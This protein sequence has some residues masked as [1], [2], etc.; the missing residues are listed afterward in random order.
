MGYDH[1]EQKELEP[2]K[3]AS[4]SGSGAS[5]SDDGPQKGWDADQGRDSATTLPD[6]EGKQGTENRRKHRPHHGRKFNLRSAEDDLPTD[7]WF[8]STAIPL[9]AAT[10]APMAN[11][12]SIAALVVSWRNNVVDPGSEYY[13]ATSVGFPDP[14]WC[15]DLNIAS[16]VCGFVGNLFL[17][18][19]FTRRVRYIVALPTTIVLFYLASGILIGLTISMNIHCPPGENQV[20]SQGYWSA[21]LAACLYMFN[22][23]ILMVNM[24]GYFLGH[25][26]QHFTLT[27]EQRNLILQ[28][29]MFFIWLGGGAGI[30]SR[31]E[32]W[33]Y[34]DAMYFCDVTILTVGFGDYFPHDDLGRGLVFPYSVGGT[35]ILG[36]MVSS[37]HKF[38][39]E[40][41]S[42]NV[43]R[44]HVE[45][46]RANTLSR[47]VTV[48][49][50]EEQRRED[51]EKEI[52][53][54]ESLGR[55]PSISSPLPNPQI[56]HDL[57]TAAAQ[58][59]L[60]ADSR[61]ERAL[62]GH[63]P[64]RQVEFETTNAKELKHPD[65]AE[66]HP[67]QFLK[68][69]H[70]K[71][72]MHA[73]FEL[74]TKPVSLLRKA[75]SRSH[76]AIVMREEKDRFEAMRAIQLNARKFKKWYALLVSVLAFG[77]LWCL[78]A[79]VFWQAEK[80]TQ[81]L[82]YF[83]ALY[84]CYVSLLTIGYGDMSPQSNAGKP[85][86]VVW[87]L[88]AVPAM[89]ILISDMGDT[90]ISSF[91]RGTFRLGDMTV[92][93]KAG[94]WHDLLKSNPWLWKFISGRA[95]K[96][97]RK[98]GLPVGPS[99]DDSPP[100]L[101]LEELADDS[102][103]EAELTHRLAWAIRKTADDLQHTPNKCYSF[104]DWCEFRR[105]IHFTKDGLAE[106]DYDEETEGVVEWD[107]LEDT[108]PMLSAQ[109]EP[110]W[111]LDRL[112][113]SLLRLIKK[114]TL[115]GASTPDLAP[116]TSSSSATDLPTSKVSRRGT[117]SP[118]TGRDPEAGNSG[119]GKDAQPR[120]ATEAEARRRRASGAEAVLTFFT[121][122]RRGVHSYV[123][124]APQWSKK[125]RER[126]K[127]SRRHRAR[128]GAV[129]GSRGGAGL[130]ALK[131]AQSA[132]DG[133]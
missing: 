72:H 58:S 39:G 12:V 125:A 40:L 30:F 71:G 117:I 90:V 74:I 106:L 124:E 22:S 36:L 10:F 129:G 67:R 35:I 86:F 70:H 13:Q 73:T 107:W 17:L 63:T 104:E 14:A 26:P 133:E 57:D 32:G 60:S 15:I 77:I 122:E 69:P 34:P 103:S 85:F 18:F 105:L 21:V 111:V 79:V 94:L 52:G 119:K 46:R 28:T 2:P 1:A 50:T 31:I 95:E 76:K 37:I 131:K 16:L 6:L 113:E 126:M 75:R 48:E 38:A 101:S 93:P 66:P 24:W 120:V 118:Q 65:Q 112:C 42:V 43:L 100:A 8:A 54:D 108:S 88:I 115:A 89:T 33:T 102:L 29:M 91:K 47:V 4:S 81:G 5:S 98:A 3:P 9:I 92:L 121:G 61:S 62:Q 132:T 51:L 123:D 45:R 83:E 84:F 130:R 68:S 128:T 127:Q 80:H 114:N 110:E 59:R 25:Y 27:D 64:E 99:E 97:R 19:N 87:S 55:K 7:W 41:S 11:L 23:M 49:D 116:P 78:G 53:E 20:Y 109:S 56:L 44:K 82:N 96:K